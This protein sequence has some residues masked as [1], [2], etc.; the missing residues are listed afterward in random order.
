[1]LEQLNKEEK[2]TEL[3]GSHKWK[4]CGR[5]AWCPQEWGHGTLRACATSGLRDPTRERSRGHPL[6]G[7]VRTAM[8]PS[9]VEL[10]DF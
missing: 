5:G 8:L 3:T 4:G 1:M 6:T 2:D 9:E 7:F 10:S